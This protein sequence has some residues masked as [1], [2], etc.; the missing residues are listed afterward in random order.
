MGLMTCAVTHMQ[1]FP[2]VEF[3]NFVSPD[4]Y[5]VRYGEISPK[6]YGE[7]SISREMARDLGPFH[8]STLK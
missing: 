3:F 4:S 1:G 7:T 8:E 6:Y 5:F 2:E